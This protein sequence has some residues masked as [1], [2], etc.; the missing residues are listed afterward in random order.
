MQQK[1][2]LWGQG[3]SIFKIEQSKETYNLAYDCFNNIKAL[4]FQG[5]TPAAENKNNNKVEWERR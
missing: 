2:K 1:Q 4:Y 3:W 5:F